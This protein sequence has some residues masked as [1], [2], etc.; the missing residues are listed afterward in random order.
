MGMSSREPPATPDAPQ[1]PKVAMML[2]SKALKNE[3]SM[4]NVWHVAKVIT[5]MVMAAPF[6]LMVLPNGM[7]T[8]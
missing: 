4:P 8:E 2:S 6:M 1:A 7:L 5:V 3:V